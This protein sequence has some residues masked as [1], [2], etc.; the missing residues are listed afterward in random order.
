MV[1]CL[2]SLVPGLEWLAAVSRVITVLKVF[3]EVAE[4]TFGLMGEV[5][6]PLDHFLQDAK[7]TVEVVKDFAKDFNEA[8]RLMKV[9]ETIGEAIEALEALDTCDWCEQEK[10]GC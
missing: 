1:S 3:T 5:L 10:A 7:D 4:H 8:D 6:T 2:A 9:S